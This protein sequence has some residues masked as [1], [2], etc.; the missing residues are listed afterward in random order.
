MRGMSRETY[1]EYSLV[2]LIFVPPHFLHF[3]ETNSGSVE[4]PPFHEVSKSEKCAEGRQ[5]DPEYGDPLSKMLAFSV[6]PQSLHTKMYVVLS[7]ILIVD[8]SHRGLLYP[9]F[10]HI[11]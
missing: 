1:S 10:N 2:T 7:I 3:T 5:A 4:P 9:F 8:F 11:A 6:A